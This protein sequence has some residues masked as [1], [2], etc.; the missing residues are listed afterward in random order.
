MKN[1]IWLFFLTTSLN[2]HGQ[3][4]S[5]VSKLEKTYKGFMTSCDKGKGEKA[6]R[7]L[8]H[9]SMVFFELMLNDLWYA[10]SVTLEKLPL[11]E[12]HSILLL[13]QLFPREKLSSFTPQTF[14]VFVIDEIGPPGIYLDEGY[15]LGDIREVNNKAFARLKVRDFNADPEFEFTKENGHWKLSILPFIKEAESCIHRRFIKNN[16]SD[17]EFISFLI[18][19]YSDQPIDPNIWKATKR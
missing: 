14:P 16:N 3:E 6:L 17:K 15:S 1:L 11:A 19:S 13:R 4:N 9:N 18:S 5:T 2:L 7:Y 12:R 8:D 10:D